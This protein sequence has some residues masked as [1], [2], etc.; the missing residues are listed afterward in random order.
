MKTLGA[1][2]FR[3]PEDV[4]LLETDHGVAI[5]FTN[6]QAISAMDEF[7]DKSFEEIRLQDYN[8]GRYRRT[9]G[10]RPKFIPNRDMEVQVRVPFK[11]LDGSGEMVINGASRMYLTKY[12]CVTAMEELENL[13]L[14]EIRLQDYSCGRHIEPYCC[15]SESLLNEAFPINHNPLPLFNGEV[16]RPHSKAFQKMN[17]RVSGDDPLFGQVFG[18]AAGFL[19]PLG[20]DYQI[21]AKKYTFCLPD[22]NSDNRSDSTSADS[23]TDNNNNSSSSCNNNNGNSNSDDHDS[24]NNCI[25]T[26]LTRILDDNMKGTAVYLNTRLMC[27][28][29]DNKYSNKSMEELRME[30]ILSGVLYRDTTRPSVPEREFYR[31][32]ILKNLQTSS[33]LTE[34]IQSN[35]EEMEYNQSIVKSLLYKAE[36]QQERIKFNLEHKQNNLEDIGQRQDYSCSLECSEVKSNRS[37]AVPKASSTSGNAE[38]SGEAIMTA[39]ET[40]ASNLDVKNCES[41]K[42]MIKSNTQA[43]GT[44][45]KSLEEV[46]SL[47]SE[48][49]KCPLKGRFNSNSDSSF[50]DRV[51]SSV[52]TT[53]FVEK[54]CNSKAKPN[55]QPLT[56]K[57]FETRL[58]TQT[59]PLSQESHLSVTKP[60]LWHYMKHS[61]RGQFEKEANSSFG[62]PSDELTTHSSIGTFAQGYSISFG[63]PHDEETTTSL[64]DSL[65]SGANPSFREPFGRW[66]THSFRDPFAVGANPSF[67]KAFDGWATHSFRDSFAQRANPS[68]GKPFGEWATHSFRD[69]FAQRANPSFG[70][71]FNGWATHS[72]RD[73]FAQRANPSFG[74]PFGEWATHSFRDSF[75]QRANPSS[76]KPFHR[77]NTHSFAPEDNLSFGKSFGG[78]TSNMF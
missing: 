11:A 40:S 59:I 35:L 49:Q 71:P 28:S 32:F 2:A 16:T 50:E 62:T 63:E 19:P 73:S 22:T 26:S 44:V 7:K 53:T 77:D 30:D 67:G 12:Q 6:H 18:T 47:Y 60:S 23:T 75:A 76:G 72:F 33:C 57:T 68:F 45:T 55:V 70:K 36:E 38:A 56:S 27:I 74:K 61:F 69:S 25:T 54:S 14:E 48:S 39:G 64:R 41:V 1:V 78:G 65:G 10:S 20:Q 34:R 21:R 31:A 37:E 58:D 29:A 3:A 24:N 5:G 13:S 46:K 4:D 17:A 42:C 15:I 43:A 52:G 66:A 51:S 9:P 8:S